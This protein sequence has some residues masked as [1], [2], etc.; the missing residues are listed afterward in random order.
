MSLIADFKIQVMLL[1]LSVSAVQLVGKVESHI[2]GPSP[3]VPSPSNQVVVIIKTIQVN[4]NLWAPCA[5]LDY[6]SHNH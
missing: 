4:S 1:L 5:Y 3:D 2:H 6:K